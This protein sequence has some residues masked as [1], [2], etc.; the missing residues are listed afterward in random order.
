MPN[1]KTSS[2]FS[3]RLHWLWK[4]YCSTVKANYWVLST[5]RPKTRRADHAYLSLRT[6]TRESNVRT[7]WW[8]MIRTLG[9][10]IYSRERRDLDISMSHSCRRW[11]V[12]RSTKSV[13]LSRP[14]PSK[15]DGFFSSRACLCHVWSRSTSFQVNDSVDMLRSAKVISSSREI[16][17]CFEIW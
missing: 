7:P 9:I 16:C 2:S 8:T 17:M 6:T 3:G 14:W 15:R 5:L 11:N 4:I 12:T 1:N 10:S 13:S